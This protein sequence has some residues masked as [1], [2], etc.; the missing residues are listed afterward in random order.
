MGKLQLVEQL[1]VAHAQGYLDEATF[2]ELPVRGTGH[3]N[4]GSAGHN[5]TAAAPQAPFCSV[6]VMLC[7]VGIELTCGC[8]SEVLCVCCQPAF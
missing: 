7:Q 3:D 8:A 1:E 2:E 5:M 4:I 6:K